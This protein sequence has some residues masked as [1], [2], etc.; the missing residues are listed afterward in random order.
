[1]TWKILNPGKLY[2]PL[3]STAHILPDSHP[4]G[5]PVVPN[6]LSL[7]KLH[8][9]AF[10]RNILGVHANLARRDPYGYPAGGR[11]ADAATWTSRVS[12]YADKHP[13]SPGASAQPRISR[14]SSRTRRVKRLERESLARIKRGRL[15]A[16]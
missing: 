8:H 2:S 14:G 16:P 4:R 13:S 1:M 10:D 11:R 12:R 6:G 3:A 7:C 15:A 5:A 9:A